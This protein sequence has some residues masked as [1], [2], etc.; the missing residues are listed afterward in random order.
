M[1]LRHGS[2]NMH[3][4]ETYLVIYIYLDSPS[5]SSVISHAGTNYILRIIAFLWYLLG[6]FIYLI[7]GKLGQLALSLFF[8]L[9][10]LRLDLF[11]IFTHFEVGT[12]IWIIIIDILWVRFLYKK[13][14]EIPGVS[15][16]VGLFYGLFGALAPL[17]YLRS[18]CDIQV[19]LLLQ[20][21]EGKRA[22]SLMFARG[23]HLRSW[24]SVVL[25]WILGQA[26]LFSCLLAFLE[27]GGDV[28]L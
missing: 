11:W 26:T 14:S 24:A 17:W 5:P 7:Y 22:V 6:L 9:W 23:V 4:K 2:T 15:F 21:L 1:I 16:P 10:F 13:V 3:K 20:T 12:S 19:N 27:P 18:S 8:S 25:F 28:R